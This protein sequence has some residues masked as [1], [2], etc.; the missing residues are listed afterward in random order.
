MNKLDLQKTGLKATPTRLA[1]V[2]FLTKQKQPLSAEEIFQK[3]HQDKFR[4]DLA[5]IYRT[6]ET[7]Y[8][9]RLVNKITTPQ[10]P[11]AKFEII[12]KDH[13]HF[14][15]TICKSVTDIPHCYIQP[16]MKDLQTKQ[17][18]VVTGHTLE[19]FGVCPK[20]Q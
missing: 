7:F 4:C 1:I 3:L 2:S 5:T 8:Q 16:I 10:F 9:K 11:M 18:M 19:F 13:H 12:S 15:C 20:C 14:T 6:L 17:H